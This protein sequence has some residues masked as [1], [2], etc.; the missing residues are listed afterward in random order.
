MSREERA[1][2]LK[3]LLEPLVE[4]LGY[5]LVKLDYAARKHGLLHL[6]IDHEKGI[7]VDD[8]E[9]VSRAVSQLLD[10]EDPISHAYTLEVSS[11]GLERPLTKAEHF[12]RFAG[13]KAKIRTREEVGGQSKF[14]GTLLGWKNN[15]VIFKTEAG[16][17][18]EIPEDLVLKA[19]LWYVKPS[20]K[21]LNK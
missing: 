19:N 4:N 13:E 14:A 20:K 2:K 16:D 11:P 7:N 21:G 1:D 9:S 18:V 10:Q 17:S 8:C 3:A 6:V 5:E 12:K 15:S